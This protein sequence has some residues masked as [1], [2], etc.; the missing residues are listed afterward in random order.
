[1]V[2]NNTSRVF[3]ACE[4]LSLFNLF[5]VCAKLDCFNQIGT[6]FHIQG[7]DFTISCVFNC[8]V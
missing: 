5:C 4:N 6:F 1:M 8:T 3:L 2:L 7:A